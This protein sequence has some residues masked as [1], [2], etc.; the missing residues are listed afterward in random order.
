MSRSLKKSLYVN[1]KLEK[2]VRKLIEWIAKSIEKGE[3]AEAD[4]IRNTPIRVWCRGST[5]YPE[6]IGFIL[7]IHNGSKKFVSRQITPEMVG[8]KIG[9]FAPTRKSGQHGKAGTH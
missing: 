8:H 3:H 5:I 2:K 6:M 7:H 1:E 4:K 9:E